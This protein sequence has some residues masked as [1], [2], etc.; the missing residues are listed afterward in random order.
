MSRSTHTIIV[1][2]ALL[3]AGLTLAFLGPVTASVIF[4]ATLLMVLSGMV[5]ALVCH[6]R[7]R[8]FWCGFAVFAGLYFFLLMSVSGTW[9]IAT[10]HE[11]SL[12]QPRRPCLVTSYLL[13]WAYDRIGGHEIRTNAGSQVPAVHLLTVQANQVPDNLDIADLEIFMSNGQ[14]LLTLLIGLLGGTLAS[15]L[16]RRA[17]AA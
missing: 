8:A 6:A 1:L 17:T 2:A 4:T 13:A 10:L 5:A 11:Q 12:D 16:Q 15:W 3:I 14:C 9:V 7:Q